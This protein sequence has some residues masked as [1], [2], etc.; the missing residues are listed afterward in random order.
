MEKL[1]ATDLKDLK[2][3]NDKLE[4]ATN[5]LPTPNDYLSELWDKLHAIERRIREYI[6]TEETR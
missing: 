3:F 2:E 5:Y 6:R 1:D 4:L